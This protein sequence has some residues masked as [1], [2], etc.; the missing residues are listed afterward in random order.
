MDI[1]SQL[2]RKSSQFLKF[3]RA[4]LATMFHGTQINFLKDIASEGLKPYKPVPYQPRAVF[5]TPNIETAATYAGLGK[6]NVPVILEINLSG[7]AR[8]NK[9]TEDALDQDR[10][11]YEESSIEHF[12]E[13]DIRYLE[14]KIRDIIGE[15]VYFDSEN[16]L[17]T[18]IIKLLLNKIKERNLPAQ[19]LNQAILEAKSK[20]KD[21]VNHQFE[22]IEI[23]E[24]GTIVPKEELYQA[25]HQV[26]YPKAIPAQA[27]KFVWIPAELLKPEIVAQAV[28]KK[29]FGQRVLPGILKQFNDVIFKYQSKVLYAK[30]FDV[31]Q[32]ILDDLEEFKEHGLAVDLFKEI[33]NTSS[34]EELKDI[35]EFIEPFD[36]GE[37]VNS[38]TWLKFSTNPTK[39]AQMESW[40]RR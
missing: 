20:I 38:Q 14:R 26:S 3:A 12:L 23:S 33:E 15:S 8:L 18:N 28:G 31:K 6:T 9:I 36:P 34:L 32:N 10:E 22:Y 1:Y 19:E 17:K 21:L 13:E 35:F 16:L 5:L 37:E 4:Y 39:L 24:N 11:V 40:I 27:I 2:A 29:N 30:N 7:T 25:Y